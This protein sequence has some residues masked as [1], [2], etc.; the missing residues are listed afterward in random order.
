MSPALRASTSFSKRQARS[1]G[2]ARSSIRFT[3]ASS[4]ATDEAVKPN[5]DAAA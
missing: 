1:I 2:A 5:T 3:F 4:I